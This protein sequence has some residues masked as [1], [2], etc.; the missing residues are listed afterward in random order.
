MADTSL[1]VKIIADPKGLDRGLDEAA[2]KVSDAGK[3][4]DKGLVSKGL[5]VRVMDFAAAGK[6]AMGVVKD[7]SKLVKGQFDGISGGLEK[8]SDIASAIPGKFGP[9]L[10]AV[11]GLAAGIVEHFEKPFIKAQLAARSAFLTVAEGSRTAAQA[12]SD[13]RFS[14]LREGLEDTIQRMQA[15]QSFGG[16]GAAPVVNPIIAEFM[17]A[18]GPGA[19]IAQMPD[20]IRRD[21]QRR[22]RM[23]EALQR[24]PQL[25][26][27][28]AETVTERMRGQA[29]GVAQGLAG[30]AEAS[31]ERGLVIAG[32]GTAGEAEDAAARLT[33]EHDLAVQIQRN[34]ETYR[35]AHDRARELLRDQMGIVQQRQQGARQAQEAAALVEQTRTPLERFAVEQRRLQ[36][37]WEA[38]E[39]D[40]ETMRRGMSNL[41]EQAAVRQRGNCPAGPLPWRWDRSR[42]PWPLP[43]PEG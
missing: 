24:D 33:M 14:A 13:V 23:L 40:E 16:G 25:Q 28:L 18:Q 9:A 43:R 1:V 15:W 12:M 7:A 30:R 36:G 41:A 37:L 32:G 4:V 3:E 38:G 22:S 10:G 19:E 6:T 17:A 2:K 31:R 39:I 21:I 29:I 8:M 27:T 42:P 20:R 11:L 35:Q 26:Q 34:N 5:T